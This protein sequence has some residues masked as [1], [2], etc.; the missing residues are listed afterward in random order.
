MKSQ[1]IRSIAP[2]MDPLRMGMGWTAEDLSRPQII[3]ESTYG[4]SHPGS[5]HL[6]A[7]VEEAVRGADESGCK[8]ARYYARTY[9]TAWRRGMTASIIRWPAGT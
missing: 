2:E 6:N 5:A 9:A 1:E 4:D 7:L 8:A 3:V